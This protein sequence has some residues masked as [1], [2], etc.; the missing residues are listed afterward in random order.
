MC[1]KILIS[2]LLVAIFNLL[3]CYSS[4][5]VTAAEYKQVEEK[6]GKPNEIYVK[7]KDYQGYH[8]S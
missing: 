2:F 5:L 6:D 3:G 1:K 7:T 4:E 8:F